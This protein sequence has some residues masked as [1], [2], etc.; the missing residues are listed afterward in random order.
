MRHKADNVVTKLNCDVNNLSSSDTYW[1]VYGRTASYKDP[2]DI[3][4]FCVRCGMPDV[5]VAREN[6]L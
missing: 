2:S 4:A 1:E 3:V 6:G 5:R